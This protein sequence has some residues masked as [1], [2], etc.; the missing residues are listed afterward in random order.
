MQT[1]VPEAVSKRVR[2]NPGLI[3]SMALSIAAGMP[4]FVLAGYWLDRKRHSEPLW[5]LCGL[6][7]G[8][9]YGAYEVWTT[10]KLAN[11]MERVRKAKELESEGTRDSHE[12]ET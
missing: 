7:L 9:V 3:F 5:T 2:S 6:F 4:L 10:L 8:L 11:E 1:G 12:A